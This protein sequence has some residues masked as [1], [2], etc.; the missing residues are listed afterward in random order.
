MDA[1]IEIGCYQLLG[2]AGAQP[3]LIN[4][5]ELVAR[6]AGLLARLCHADRSEC[7]AAALLHDLGRARAAEKL[8]IELTGG[9]VLPPGPLD[10]AQLGAII[11]EAA[12]RPYVRLADAVGRHALGSV[13]TN[14]PP[15][16][17][18]EQVV[19]LADKMV[20][21]TWLGFRGRIGDLERRY[22]HLYDIR[23][24]IPGA[25]AIFEHLAGRACLSATSLE[26]MV[27]REMPE[28]YPYR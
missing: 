26:A 1:S 6:A 14:A 23:L 5:T 17:A 9:G 22:G 19:F 13:L 3:G 2:R 8:A 21:R 12:G 7:V 16:S 11:V 10:H 15:E 27:A 24:C 25:E 20:G 28:S 4:H 18:V